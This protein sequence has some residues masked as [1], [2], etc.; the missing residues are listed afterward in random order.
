MKKQYIQPETLTVRTAPGQHLLVT[1]GDIYRGGEANSPEMEDIFEI[2]DA[3]DVELDSYFE[4][5]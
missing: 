4:S 2:G 1:S 3:L 5:E